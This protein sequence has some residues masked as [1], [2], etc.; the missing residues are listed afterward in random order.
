MLTITAGQRASFSASMSPSRGSSQRGSSES[1]AMTCAE[2]RSA[3][4]DEMWWMP[5]ARSS[6][7]RR[8]FISAGCAS[9]KSRAEK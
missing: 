9:K 3:V 1:T 2:T 5:T 6:S 8:S 4:R 7:E